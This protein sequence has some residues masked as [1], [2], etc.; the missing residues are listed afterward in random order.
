M[1]TESN[2]FTKIGDMFKRQASVKNNTAA[3]EET[4]SQHK[5]TEIIE[6][7]FKVTCDCAKDPKYKFACKS[8]VKWF[9]NKEIMIKIRRKQKYDHD[10]DVSKVINDEYIKCKNHY[11]SLKK[12]KP[13]DETVT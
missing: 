7:N 13:R 11:K 9:T 6:I 4:K 10:L 3:P 5:E 2:L 8:G 12:L 1:S